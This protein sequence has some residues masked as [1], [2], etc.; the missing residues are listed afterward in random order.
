MKRTFHTVTSLACTAT[1]TVMTTA[2][3]VSTPQGTTGTQNI[4][5]NKTSSA[6]TATAST[7]VSKFPVSLTDDTG[8]SV[9]VST[10]PHHIASGTEGTD[11]ILTALVPKSDIALVT[12]LASNPTYSNVVNQVTGIPQMQHANPEK[13]LSVHP[14]LVLLASY[15]K[16]GVVKQVRNAGVPVY[17]FHDFTSVASIEKNIK[18]IG[19]LVGA[20]KKANQ[21][22]NQMN[23]NITKIKDAVAKEPKVS[24]LDYSSYGFAGGKNT[25]V[26]DIITAA[27]G[28]NA[29]SALNGWQKISD[30]QIVK[31]N[32]DVI[33]D[34][35]GD[36]AFLKKLANDPGLQNVTAI[37]EHHLYS[38]PDADLS[39]V[40]QY[41]VK[42][43]VDLAHDI[44]PNAAMPN[45]QV[46]P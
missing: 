33:I 41:I 20:T 6:N 8:A 4:A 28:T 11:E 3:G 7:E 16:P 40:S 46:K 12:S 27:G 43:M 17:E 22:V 2:C 34:S 36:K 29:A 35:K 44:H 13:I 10:Q 15:V 39:S 37:K 5:G 30:E 23:D 9:V 45:I 14:D 1:L 26:N 19:Q 18:V 21:V 24:V 38:I 42:G 32:P 31:M 25:T